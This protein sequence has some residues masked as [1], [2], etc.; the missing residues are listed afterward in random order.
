MPQSFHYKP[1]TADSD[2]CHRQSF[3]YKPLTADS[4]PCLEDLSLPRYRFPDT[5][6]E[7]EI[8]ATPKFSKQIE[9]YTSIHYTVK[10]PIGRDRQL[11]AHG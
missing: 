6:L 1:L 8:Y 7:P 3:Q 5:T 9:S 2:P 4:D 11:A 10:Q